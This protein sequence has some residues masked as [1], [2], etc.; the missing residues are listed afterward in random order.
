[1]RE[2]MDWVKYNNQSLDFKQ[3]LDGTY[4]LTKGTCRSAKN[5]R[6]FAKLT[7]NLRQQMLP[8][9][10]LYLSRISSHYILMKILFHEFVLLLLWVSVDG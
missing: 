5:L 4:V 10:K 2:M 6:N 7:Y 1:M 8:Y 9:D 3:S